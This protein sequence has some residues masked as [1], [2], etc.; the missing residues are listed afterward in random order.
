MGKKEHSDRKQH[1]LDKIKH[2][3]TI[4]YGAENR[5]SIGGKQYVSLP[6]NSPAKI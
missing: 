6:I 1:L 2:R 3:Y 5:V 4:S